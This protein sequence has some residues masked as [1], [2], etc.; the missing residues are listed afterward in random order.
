MEE[1]IAIKFQKINLKQV[2][3]SIWLNTPFRKSSVSIGLKEP[4]ER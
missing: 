1:L 2:K 3:H 4:E